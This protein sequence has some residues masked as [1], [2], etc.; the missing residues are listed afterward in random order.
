MKHVSTF[1]HFLKNS[2]NLNQTRLDQL[3]GRVESIVDCLKADEFIGGLYEDH[4]PQGSWAHKTIIRPV[5]EYDE[6][7][8]DFLVKFKPESAWLEDPRECLHD[9]RAVFKRSETYKDMVEKKNRCVR[10]D[11]AN[12]CHIDVVPFVVFD[13]G[14]QLIVNYADNCFEKTNPQG[15]TVWMKEKDDLAG[16][17][18][19]RVIRLLKYLRDLKNTFSCRSVI[20]TT[21]VGGRIRPESSGYADLPTALLT[22]LSDLNTWLMQYPAM[23]QIEDPSCPGTTFNHRWNEDQYANFR[24]KISTYTTL[25]KQ[26]YD[27]PDEEKSL[28]GWQKIF[29]SNFKRQDS[30]KASLSAVESVRGAEPR[31][32]EEEFIEEKGFRLLDGYHATIDCTVEKRNG[33]R[34]GSLR[35]IGRVQK[36]LKLNFHVTTNVPWPFTL[37]WKVRNRGEEAADVGQLRGQ[38]LKDDGRCFRQEHTLYTGEHY[39]EAYVVKDGMLFARSHYSV[40]IA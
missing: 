24:S 40:N 22:I 2:V 30:Q 8:A 4:I 19:R 33:F 35:E 23:P 31:A 17:H 3:A 5:G 10:L 36:G 28:E 29:G 6:F 26:A 32:P 15:F 1:N 20:L 38:L 14:R 13:D 9:L 34:T 11:Y 18:L 25:V 12:D 7:D 21:L 39:V 27:E 16:G 37:L